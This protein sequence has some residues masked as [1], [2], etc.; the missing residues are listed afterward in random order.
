[1]DD[2]TERKLLERL[3]RAEILDCITRYARGMDRLD[4]AL[5]RSA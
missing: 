1:M 4:R 3:D 5:A 2:H